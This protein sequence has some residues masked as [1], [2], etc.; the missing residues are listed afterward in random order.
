MEKIKREAVNSI[1][2]RKRY[3]CL[4]EF[5]RNKVLYLMTLPAIILV[6]IFS[7][8][9]M[10]GIV[11]AFKDNK[12]A[13]GYFSGNWVGFQNFEFFF[14]SND[15]ARITFNTVFLNA[16][17]IISVLVV[18]LSLALLLNELSKRWLVKTYQSVMFFPYFLSWVI[19]GFLTFAFLSVDNGFIN[20][21]LIALGREPVYWYSNP[22]YWPFILTIVN[23]LKNAGYYCIIYYAGIT[24]IDQDLY[25][26]ASIDGASR[27][28]RMISITIPSIMPLISVMVLLQ[29]GKIF[30]ADFGLFYYVPRETG[31]LFP[32]TDVIDTYAFRALRVLGN[33][34]MS[35]AIGLFQSFVGFVLVLVSN[36]ITK[37]INSDNALF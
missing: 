9:P 29:I 1:A 23:L 14:R 30:Y 12:S 31:V 32:R 7:Y 17:F 25:E 20:K 36:L 13:A 3:N 11:M 34:G 19:I 5:R 33:T 8:I 2:Q 10:F 28:R 37:K 16:L 18:S 15:A 4:G 6:F 24:G 21:I 22:N 27:F 35:A 26:A